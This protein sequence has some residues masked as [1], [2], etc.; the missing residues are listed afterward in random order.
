MTLD[1]EVRALERTARARP[2]DGAAQV[3]LAAALT[4]VGRRREA[5]EAFIRAA[6]AE[7]GDPEIVQA[8]AKVEWWTGPRGP[9][10]GSRALRV[11]GAQKLPSLTKARKLGA[12]GLGLAVGRGVVVARVSDEKGEAHLEA[13][14][15]ATGRFLWTCQEKATVLAAAPPLI[16][17][18]AVIDAV[19]F[20]EQEDKRARLR[21]R[22][23][24]LATGKLLPLNVELDLA[25][26]PAPL[27]FE[28]AAVAAGCI[29]LGIVPSGKIDFQPL[30]KVF[31]VETGKPLESST[32]RGL[33]ELAFDGDFLVL[34]A[35]KDA[36]RRIEA[37][38]LPSGERLWHAARDERTQR[39]AIEGRTV[40]AATPRRR[41]SPRRRT[42]ST[43][44]LEMA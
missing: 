29:V 16:A 40:V 10:G 24:S 7:P 1:A 4:R 17:G 26:P 41:S 36:A 37:R 19:V 9:G 5:L 2:D 25:L 33:N 28:G 30:V 31:D 12:T 27:A 20:I 13:L 6:A 3:G 35:A 23:F 39:L 34:S 22:A 18:D 44:C 32:V 42:R 38:R 8:L 21:L 43:P 15:L 14:A 11:T